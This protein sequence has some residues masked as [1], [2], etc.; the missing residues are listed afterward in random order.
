M[1][2]F[3]CITVLVSE[4]P[5]AGKVL[6][7]P[8]NSSNMQKRTFILIFRSYEPNWVKKGYFESDLRFQ[9]C[10]ITHC[11]P[12]TSVFVLIE[13]I[14]RY[15]IQRNYLKNRQFSANFFW[16]LGIRIKF[17]MFWKK[18]EPHRSSVSE[19]IVSERCACLNASLVLFLKILWQGKC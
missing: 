16:I 15:Q 7:S 18:N 1:C 3:K 12:T 14:Y 9:D 13:R 4:N 8:K 11:L 2:L 10:L 6:T 17:S 5:L 19:V